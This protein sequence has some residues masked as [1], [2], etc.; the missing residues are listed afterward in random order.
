MKKSCNRQTM[1]AETYSLFPWKQFLVTSCL[2][3]IKSLSLDPLSLFPSTRSVFVYSCVS[4]CVCRCTCVCVW[5]CMHVCVQ[6][7]VFVFECAC[8]C[9]HMHVSVVLSMFMDSP[10]DV[11]VQTS[12]CAQTSRLRH[13]LL[14]NLACSTTQVHLSPPPPLK[15]WSSKLTLPWPCPAQFLHGCRRSEHKHFTNPAISLAP[16]S[17]CFGS[18]QPSSKSVFSWKM[19]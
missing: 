11:T 8:V 12:F 17:E 6:M 18:S 4:V 15:H 5:V 9:V 16:D 14:M 13:A 2:G 10:A 3:H 7:H 19:K 1:K